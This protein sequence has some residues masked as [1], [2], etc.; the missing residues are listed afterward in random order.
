MRLR[1]AVDDEGCAR[2]GL[3]GSRDI[4]VGVEVVRS[5]RTAA[6]GEDRILHREGFIG[7]NAELAS[8][9]GHTL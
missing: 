6:Q 2:Q 1:G 5:G 8:R 7:A 3:E 9:V 4:A